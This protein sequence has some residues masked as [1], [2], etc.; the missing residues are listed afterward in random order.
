MSMKNATACLA[1][2]AVTSKPL[3]TTVIQTE[4]IM[5]NT[6]GTI[7]SKVTGRKYVSKTIATFVA[8]A[9]T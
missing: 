7:T 2:V 1:S 8:I 6:E 3:T 9:Q 4:D 5:K